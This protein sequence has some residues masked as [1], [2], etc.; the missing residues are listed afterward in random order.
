MA[1]AELMY[2]CMFLG[3]LIAVYTPNSN[4]SACELT[5]GGRYLLL[6]LEG[7]EN[8]LTLQLRGRGVSDACVQREEYG[9][10]ENNGKTFEL[11]DTEC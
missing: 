7:H 11:K 2:T 5:C 9:T 4:V 3:N 10:V 1:F 6:A 8:M